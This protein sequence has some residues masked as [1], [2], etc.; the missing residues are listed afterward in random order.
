MNWWQLLLVSLA[1][2]LGVYAAFVVWLFVRR[3]P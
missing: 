1:V 3:S 2:V